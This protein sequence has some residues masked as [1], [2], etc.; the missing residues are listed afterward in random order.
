[1][2]TE[3]PRA[4]V[5]DD[6][7]PLDHNCTR[8]EWSAGPGRSCLSADGEPGGLLIVGGTPVRGAARP[9]ASKIG[10]YIRGEVQ[11][12][13][14]GKVVYDHAVKCSAGST[15]VKMQQVVPKIEQCRPYLATVIKAAKPSRIVTLGT[16][17]ALAVLGRSLDMDS[18]RK[19]YGWLSDGTP[20]F[21][22][23]D[24]LHGSD[25]RFLRQN[26]E[27]DFAWALTTTVP[28]PT[29]WDG[30]CYVV[31]TEADAL[32]AEEALEFQDRVAFDVETAGELHDHDFTILCA[33]IAPVDPLETDAYVW[34]D[35]G[36]E[37]P[38]ARAVLA[39]IL[40]TKKVTGSNIKFDMIAAIQRIGPVAN[41]YFDTQLL[42]KLMEPTSM[43]RLE[44]V[45][46]LVGRGGH[47]EEAQGY[48]KRAIA[49]A[50]RKGHREGEAP[51]DHWC[52]KAIKDGGEAL[53]YAY[54]LLPGEVLWRYNARDAATSAAGTTLLEDR[55]YATAP[56][57]MALWEKV[58]RPAIPSFVRIERTGMQAD[59]QAFEAFA[60]Y[61]NTRL[62]IL[63]DGFKA[64]GPDFNPSSVAQVADIL[65]KQLKLPIYEKSAKT[66]APST[67]AKT[68]QRLRGMHPF[69]DEMI[70]YRSL[71]KMDGTY[72]T[73]MIK[74]ITADGRIHS[75]FKLDGTETGR[76]SSENPNSQNIPRPDSVEGKMARDGFTASPGRVLVSLDY[77]Q[78]ELRV[79]AAMSG[80]PEMIQIFNSGIDY[81]LR[82]AQLI[83]KMMWG[84]EEHMVGKAH[85][86]AAKGVNFGLLYGKTDQGL[87]ET[88]GC[89]VADAAKIRA[90]ILGKFKKLAE[91]IKKLL[92]QAKR[93]GE[94]EISWDATASHVRPLWQIGSQDKWKK[95]NAE[96]SS[97]NTPIQGLAAWYA[98]A[99]LPLIHAWIDAN[100]IPAD[101]VSTVHDSI[102]LDVDP[103]YVDVVISNVR[104]IMTSFDCGGVPL[105]ADAD[106]G[107]RWGSLRGIEDGE[108]YADAQIRWVAEALKKDKAA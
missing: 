55:A 99:A 60:L 85:R 103:D 4:P 50:R 64:W 52:V 27:E 100:D 12:N 105:V 80:D 69:V 44:Y 96:N 8:C 81:H 43:G 34:T 6:A 35:K 106:A 14:K 82:T 101:I 97:I 16:W 89:S 88:L 53:R 71:E 5:E 33:G 49:A 28:P 93:T 67:D 15:K 84:I 98:L 29:H 59:R 72:A 13:W 56:K 32:A 86:S 66:G 63:R 61:L 51:K 46:H 92:T 40:M 2:Y 104:R 31:E 108:T 21:T 94:I 54:G 9:F 39:R 58:Y 25:N 76:I 75:T 70:E 26:F 47:K 83:S 3:A 57:R 10:M 77:G 79:A 22:V 23:E 91:L 73:G 1:M 17:A 11:K 48:L 95:Q 20:V 24:P 41:A 74:H 42:R 62:D 107:F 36:L 90:A 45:A 102:M 18:S 19:G 38:K 78:L 65:F 37:D 7:L 68:L 30:R 87:A